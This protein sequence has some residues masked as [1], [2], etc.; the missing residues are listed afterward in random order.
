LSLSDID[1]RLADPLHVRLRQGG[2][3]IKPAGDAYTRELRDL[4]QQA[5][6]PPWRRA[7]VP[8]LYA[9]NEIVSVADRWM[10]ARG[11]AIFEQV[12]AMP[13]WSASR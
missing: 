2:E 5:M 1:A 3:R 10:S 6:I 13:R 11:K 4:F 7:G 9:G 12:G 8:L